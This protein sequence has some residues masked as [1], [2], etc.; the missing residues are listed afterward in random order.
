MSRKY[1][2]GW[3]FNDKSIY[4]VSKNRWKIKEEFQK[5][6]GLSLEPENE[7]FCSEDVR[8]PEGIQQ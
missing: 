3:I 6:I 4:K 1:H 2:W 5:I 8:K 7:V